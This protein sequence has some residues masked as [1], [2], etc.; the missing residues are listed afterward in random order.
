MLPRL[1]LTFPFIAAVFTWTN[2][3]GSGSVPARH[4]EEISSFIAKE[5]YQ[6]VAVDEHFVYAVGSRS[7]GKYD[8]KTGKVVA[9][10]EGSKS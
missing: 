4:F 9:H 6:G 7:I 5:A 1:Y 10:W 8:K 2:A 3:V